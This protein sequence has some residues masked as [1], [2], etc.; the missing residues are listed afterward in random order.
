MVH[1][2]C[3][4]LKDRK[5]ERRGGKDSGGEGRRGEERREGRIKEQR[6]G[7]KMKDSGG[8]LDIFWTVRMSLQ[9]TPNP[10]TIINKI[11]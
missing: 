5:K 8:T 10:F 3:C 6:E 4:L 9:W 2:F 11:F 1:G 7:R